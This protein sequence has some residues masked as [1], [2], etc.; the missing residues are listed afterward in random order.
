VEGDEDLLGNR[1]DGDGVDVGVAVGLEDSLGIGAVGLVAGDVGS[2][3]VGGEEDD[4][5]AEFLDLARPEVGRA[6][7]L[8]DDGGGGH[9]GEEGQKGLAGQ[10]PAI[11]DLPR[12]V[13]HGVLE[14]DLCDVDADPVILV[15]GLLLV[16]FPG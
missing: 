5:M 10:A 8:H 1:L 14:D 3:L 4:P 13:G 12:L 6:A 16:P 7:G 2:D 15:H 11:G 9:L